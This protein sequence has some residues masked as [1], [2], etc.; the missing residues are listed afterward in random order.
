MNGNFQQLIA[1]DKPVLIDFFAEWCGPCKMMAPYLKAVKEKLGDQLTVVKIDIDKNPA[2]AQQLQIQ[3]V[4]T[5]ALYQNGQQ[6]WRQSG[7]L[8]A[9]QMEQVIRQKA[10]M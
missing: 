8:T 5:L 6:L 9:Q 1:S 4:P 3:S 10:S 2:L 7:V